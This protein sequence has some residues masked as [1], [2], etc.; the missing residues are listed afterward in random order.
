MARTDRSGLTRRQLVLGAGAAAAA[1]GAAVGVGGC[2]SSS[3]P[4]HA[5]ASSAGTGRHA[6][7]GAP[8]AAATRPVPLVP[9][10]AQPDGLPVRQ[11]AWAATLPLN[12]LGDSI[13]PLYD[14]LLFFNVPGKPGPNSARML[15]ASLRTLERRFK[16]G[17]DGLL[18]TAG[19]SPDYFEHVL[20]VPS[21]IPYAKGLSNFEL[22]TIDS[23]HLCLH[24]AC[25]DERT[26]A[27]VEGALVH[28]S[29]L[30]GADGPLDISAALHWQETRTGFVGTGLPAA[31]QN[32]GGIP[33]GD[34]VPE[35]S[36]LFMG[37]KSNFVKNQA[38][39]DDVT[40]P[41][42]PFAQGTTQH[43]SYMR[44]RLD[45][46][47]QQ[48]SYRERVQRMY[49]PETTPEDVAQ[50]TTNPPTNA[51]DLGR[52]IDH[53]GVIG[54]AQ[55]S[56]RARRN[57]RPLIIRRDFDTVDGGQAGLHFVAVQRT[58]DDFVKTRNAMNAS[59]A[60]LQNP[61]IT[62]TVNN[63]INEFIFVLKRANY[64]LPSR[65]L[66]SFPLLP[67]RGAVL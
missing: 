15:E 37:F 43:V 24:L 46:W 38:T 50:F 40:I 67:G 41:T 56:A 25:N 59:G 12:S 57:G 55:C 61:A 63:G 62:D 27:D 53:Y 28:G 30:P 44:L 34:H 48:L 51:D 36:P 9:L 10:G 18:F 42:G 7:T 26:L 49:S 22:P 3:K 21:P 39:E 33:P 31:H 52:A 16:W 11:H 58:I 14:R 29:G 60:Q 2:G 45:S 54:H 65:P 66:R 47:Y 6:N 4:E 5:G 20:W 32:V 13:V 23:Y 17:P 64:I 19:W 35:S 8:A 1:G